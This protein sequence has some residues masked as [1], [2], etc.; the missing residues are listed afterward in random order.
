MGEPN[1]Q[2]QLGR[3]EENAE[4]EGGVYRRGCRVWE[5]RRTLAT[6]FFFLLSPTFH[7]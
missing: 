5:P 2:K 3:A 7:F 4:E 6:P 1:T